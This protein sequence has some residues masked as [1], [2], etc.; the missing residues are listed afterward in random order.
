MAS[1]RVA[2]P[3]TPATVSHRCD[4]PL[5]GW[6]RVTSVFPPE[7]IVE[8]VME[9]VFLDGG[10]AARILP[11]SDRNRFD[12]LLR[13]PAPVVALH[14]HLAGS[15]RLDGADLRVRPANAI[16]ALTRLTL[17]SLLVGPGAGL[18]NAA[19]L[20]LRVARGDIVTG[21]L[22]P[23]PLPDRETSWRRLLD[24]RP[25]E[26][27]ARHVERATALGDQTPLVSIMAFPGDR[28]DA[29]AM[30]AHVLD[31]V[32]GR[33]ELIVAGPQ[34]PP[35]DNRLRDAAAEPAGAYILPLPPG[36]RLRPHALLDLIATT[37]AAPSARLIFA[38]EAIGT[39]EDDL[40]PVF[41]PDWSPIAGTA[42]DLVGAPILFEASALTAAGG[43]RPGQA[44]SAIADAM[45]RVAETVGDEG[46]RHLAKVLA[47][48]S[49]ARTIPSQEWEP[50]ALARVARTGLSVRVSREPARR[51]VRLTPD[52]APPPGVS[53]IMP[54]RDRA[55]LLR[56]SV[57]SLVARTDYPEYEILIVDNGSVEEET[58]RL[59]ASWRDDRRIRVIPAPG[60]FNYSRLNNAAIR[61]ARGEVVVLLNNDVEAL[62]T[63]WLREM[64]GWAAMRDIGCVG[65][66]LLYP[67]G[68]IQH[69]GVTPG[70]GHVF[71]RS[72][73][74]WAGPDDRL[75]S[76]TEVSAVTAACLAVRRSVYEELGGLD[77]EDFAVG[78]NDIDFCL[79]AAAAGYRNLWT[80]HAVLTHHESMSRGKEIT[81]KRLGRFG[82]E[83]R[84]MD[85]RWLFSLTMDPFHSP[86]Q[87]REDESG[88]LRE[89]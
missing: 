4:P 30:A 2:H 49:E 8:A 32:Y 67:D 75:V 16:A 48:R 36:L 85:S 46:I 72:P 9:L 14:L 13:L 41:K 22:R 3:D 43:L 76:L 59:F 71:K 70:V 18:R 50:I 78:F 37:R 65:A 55:D 79:K 62:E 86:H 63:G 11:R 26:H 87:T 57:G 88:R 69:A 47:Y 83:I 20:A 52:V 7:G 28:A 51:G 58:K 31:Q 77:E 6:I 66:K 40:V 89:R 29:E 35:L 15:A 21:P 56:L 60:P 34:P 53:I 38:D 17:R 27:R 12:L 68:T 80:P 61:E 42:R 73:G 54:T 39:G 45:L 44:A 23:C 19:R 24:E 84:A 10:R 1:L 74:G 33:W 64:A 81:P 82:R 25:Q 5:E